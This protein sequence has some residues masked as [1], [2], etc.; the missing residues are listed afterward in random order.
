V[1]WNR[2]FETPQGA[3]YIVSE[4]LTNAGKY[5]QASTIA[6]QVATVDGV[7][8]VTVRDDGIGRAEFGHGSGL[9]G[10]QDR[11]AAL[12]AGSRS[13]APTGRERR[14]RSSFRSRSKPSSLT[15]VD[16]SVTP[17]STT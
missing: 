6:V 14:S 15:T 13:S 11:V 2:H 5:A 7:V 16:V 10:L 17:T 1:D 8:R 9:V 12:G 3:Y 4:A